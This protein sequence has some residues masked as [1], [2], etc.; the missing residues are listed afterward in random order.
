MHYEINVSK[1]TEASD[2]Y[3]PSE[4]GK[5]HHLFATTSRS[6]TSERELDKVMKIFV[7]KFPAPEFCISITKWEE[8]GIGISTAK[9][10]KKEID[11]QSK[12][13]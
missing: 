10:I 6:I 5:Y 8:T 3:I 9:W 1:R 11:P 12:K 4:I 13:L 7:K 2:G